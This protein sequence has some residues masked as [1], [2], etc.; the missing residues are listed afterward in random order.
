MTSPFATGAAAAERL[1]VPGGALQGPLFASL[2]SRWVRAP[3][4][5]ERGARIGPYRI[6]DRLGHGGMAVVYLAERADGEFEQRVAL[7]LVS[8]GSGG[9]PEDARALLRRER[10]ILAG[11]EHPHIARLLDGGT[12]ED[13][14][15]WFAME[16]VEGE[17]ID[18]WCDGAGADRA[19]RLRLFGQVC[20]AVGFAHARLL[21]HRDLKPSNILVTAS[22]EVKLLD[23]GVAALTQPGQQDATPRA[24]TPGYASPEQRR[25]E[26]ETTASDVWQLGR[27]LELLCPAPR[28]GRDL[29]AIVARARHDEPARRYASV[30]ELGDDVRRALERRPVLARDAGWTYSALRFVDRHR[31]SSAIAV[32]AI[33]AIAALAVSFT[34][35]LTTERDAAAREAQRANAAVGF[36]VDLFRSNDPARNQG[37]VPDAKQLLARGVERLDRDLADQPEVRARLMLAIAQIYDSLGEAAA[38]RRLLDDA[39][40]LSQGSPHFDARAR[41]EAALVRA[42]IVLHHGRP[43]DTLDLI[44][45]LEPRID[46]RLPQGRRDRLRLVSLRAMAELGSGDLAAASTS[47][48]EALALGRELHGARS[49]EVAHREHDLGII[50]RAQGRHLEAADAFTAAADLYRD[51][52]GENHPEYAMARKSV[53]Q[54]LIELG[55]LDRAE[56]ILL[57]AVERF[58]TLYDGKGR[59]YGTALRSIAKLQQLRGD[60]P[61]ALETCTRALALMEEAIGSESTEIAYALHLHGDL[62]AALDDADGA[63]ADFERALRIR[64]ALL[65]EGHPERA[66]SRYAV[67]RQL[68]RLGRDADAEAAALQAWESWR[69]RFGD[70]HPPSLRALVLAGHAAQSRGDTAEAD[71]RFA[72][73]RTL[74]PEK[75]DAEVDASIR[76]PEE[77]YG[78]RLGAHALARS[79]TR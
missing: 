40:T 76:A 52:L 25:G 24:M 70:A 13:G 2:I 48:S 43:L 79:E 29:D 77:G 14:E 37:E 5:F 38:A 50:L 66:G 51:T 28:R 78:T 33:A 19:Q 12:T 56:P 4:E 21:V 68:W 44:R 18:R 74:A 8:P 32:G 34:L 75:L 57:D 36:M 64:S 58:R 49:A 30:R 65:P 63:L 55:E 39:V 53:A 72:L 69:A 6:L 15:L 22:G 10:Q 16:V 67:A 11:L 26:A 71:R 42:E 60:L 7:K 59:L 23:F 31:V 46:A 35:R 3:L 9:A 17:R 1:L 54:A 45:E 41:S 20:D 62:L 73:A 47:A 61:A 27:L